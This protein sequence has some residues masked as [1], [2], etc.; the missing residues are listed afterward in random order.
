MNR[1]C[2]SCDVWRLPLAAVGAGR[3]AGEV[4]RRLSVSHLV[5]WAPP[6]VNIK[7]LRLV[8]LPCASFTA[9]TV[10]GSI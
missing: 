10:V 2:G 3:L 5:G 8:E 1:R 6:A 7:V 9:T 4:V